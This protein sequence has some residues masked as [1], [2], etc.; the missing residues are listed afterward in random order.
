MEATIAAADSPGFL[1]L[2]PL[3]TDIKARAF[4]L[5]R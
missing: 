4:M 2:A 3:S 1:Y 5:L